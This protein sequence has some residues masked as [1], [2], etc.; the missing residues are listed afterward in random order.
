LLR[1]A[2]VAEHLGVCNATVY[3]LCERGALPHLRIG[4]S[5]RIGPDDLNQFIT[6]RRHGSVT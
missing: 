6:A 5:I 4:N 3:R 1:V 2:D